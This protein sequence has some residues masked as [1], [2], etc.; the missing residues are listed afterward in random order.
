MARIQARAIKDWALSDLLRD[1]LMEAGL[2][3]HDGAEGQSW[4]WR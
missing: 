1:Q 2:E 3:I 4:S